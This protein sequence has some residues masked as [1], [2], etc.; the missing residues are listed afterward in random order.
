MAFGEAAYEW[1]ENR[2]FCPSLL[3]LDARLVH[4]MNCTKWPIVQDLAHLL[5]LG[6]TSCTNTNEVTA[7]IQDV[8]G[9]GKKKNIREIS[10]SKF[11]LLNSIVLCVTLPCSTWLRKPVT[12]HMGRSSAGFLWE[13]YCSI[14]VCTKLH[15]KKQRKA[16]S[17]ATTAT[18]GT[19]DFWILG[20][21]VYFCLQI[22]CCVIET[23]M[24]T[25]LPLFSDGRC[26]C[27]W[28]FSQMS[29]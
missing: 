23:Q 21:A 14:L 6:L 27:G 25:V 13:N 28:V 15:N 19:D 18:S 20:V 7:R 8:H 12:G 11:S 5:H 29:L 3:C 16:H 4:T 1:T 24:V 17:P 22:L 26:V 10:P 2:M 9:K